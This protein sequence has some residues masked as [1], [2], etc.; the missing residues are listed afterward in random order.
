MTIEDAFNAAKFGHWAWGLFLREVIQEIGQDKA[1]ELMTKPF[2][3][4]V[5]EERATRIK[6]LMET[7]ALDLNSFAT[8]AETMWRIAGFNSKVE[9]TPTSIIT[10]TW[11]CPLYEGFLEAGIDHKT[12]EAY[13]RGKDNAGDAEYKRHLS[14]DAGLIMR[15]F[16]SES[17]D[18]C[19]EE[20]IFL[21]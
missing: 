4:F 6:T 5:R 15:K 12:I 19:I 8:Q 3:K 1:L 11:K 14:P 7:K 20:S 17:D 13:C 16:R 2:E 21:P 9:A 10:T 18:F